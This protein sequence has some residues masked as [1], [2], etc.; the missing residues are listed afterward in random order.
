MRGIKPFKL[1]MMTRTFEWKRQHHLG[2]TIFGYFAF[3]PPGTLI[4]DVDMWPEIGELYGQDFAP[5]VGIPKS[6]SEVLVLGAAHQP[7]G[8]PGPTCPVRVTVGGLDKQL[9]VIGDRTWNGGVPSQPQP[10]TRMPLGWANAFGGEGYDKNPNG[11]G[12]APIDGEDGKPVHPLPNVEHA[13]QLITSPK[14]RPEPAGL[15]PIDF[16]WPQRMSMVGTY[17]QKWLDTLF[18]GFAEDLDWRI[19]NCAAPDQQQEAPFLGNEPVRVENMHPGKPVLQTYLP[20]I[21]GRAFLTRHATSAEGQ[22]PQVE[23]IDM[24]LTTAWLFPEIEKGLVVFQGAVTV[25]EDDAADV[26]VVMVGCDRLGQERSFEHFAAVL[27]KRLDKEKLEEH[28]NDA[29]LVPPDAAGLGKE[30]EEH[31]AL[32]THENLRAKRA[33]VRAE[34]NVEKARAEVASFGLD[35]DEHG[36][37]PVEPLREPPKPSEVPALVAQIKAEVE[38]KLEVARAKQKE[39][40]ENAK[41]VYDELGLDFSEVEREMEMKQAG[42]PEFTAEGRR[43]EFRKMADELAAS[44]HPSDEIEHYASDEGYFEKLQNY[45]SRLRASYIAYA[46]MQHPVARADGDRSLEIQVEIDEV[47]R[48]GGELK[49]RDFT[50]ADLGGIDL[51]GLDFSDCFF[52]S[53]NLARCNLAGARFDR[54]VLAH[55]DLTGARLR[56]ASFVGTN[57]GKASLREADSEGEVDFT[58]ATLW[59]ADLTGARLSGAKLGGAMLL[60]VKLEGADLANAHGPQL[61]FYQTSMQKMRFAGAHLKESVFVELDLA[62]SDFSGAN[63]DGATFVSCRLDQCQ[64]VNTSLVNARVVQQS[65]MFN[66]DLKGA[67]LEQANFGEQDMRGSDLSGAKLNK[68]NLSGANL[69]GCRLYRAV[70]REALLMK[71]SFKDAFLVSADL[72]GAILQKADLRGCDMRGANLYGADFALVRSDRGTNVTDAIQLKTR[73]KPRREEPE[74]GPT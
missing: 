12:F 29:D 17:D 53:A 27:E 33:Q 57:L 31:F 19:W 61:F 46:H 39:T 1:G 36:P 54:A 58:D 65:R 28:L 24:R 51:S 73:T 38:A 67:N 13:A 10:F 21:K 48:S 70:A 26:D 64:M 3:D 56:G 20:G 23:E 7:G 2:V 50:G 5:D 42:P 71:T 44:G 15:G 66:V 22:P 6:R 25:L 60:N 47:R 16:T 11:K 30:I 35:P 59:E 43:A 9:Y 55:A 40:L 74:G 4:A 14:D 63:L 34:K 37:P 62:E 52:E 72:M 32:T 8:R 41:A 18:P 45:E 69:E 49:G 68:A